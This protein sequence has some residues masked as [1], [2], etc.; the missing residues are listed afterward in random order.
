MI[1]GYYE[2]DRPRFIP[3][4]GTVTAGPKNAKAK[5]FL[6]EK[7]KTARDRVEEAEREAYEKAM[8]PTDPLPDQPDKLRE[9]GTLPGSRETVRRGHAWNLLAWY[10]H[11]VVRPM[12]VNYHRIVVEPQLTWWGRI[13]AL[14][15]QGKRLPTLDELLQGFE[16]PWEQLHRKDVLEARKAAAAAGEKQADVELRRLEKLQED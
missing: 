15:G 13:K 6:E 3:R 1:P 2:H 14:F 10:H 11:D 16:S 9:W 7:H 4:E 12:L 8:R 5:D